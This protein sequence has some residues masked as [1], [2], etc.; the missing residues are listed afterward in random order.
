MPLKASAFLFNS[1]SFVTCPPPH[2]TQKMQAAKNPPSTPTATV[3]VI[4]ENLAVA[5]AYFPAAMAQPGWRSPLPAASVAPAS[6]KD[7][8]RAVTCHACGGTPA[9]TVRVMLPTLIVSV[10]LT[11]PTPETASSTP[12]P[13]LPSKSSFAVAAHSPM[14]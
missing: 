6:N 1:S 3:V 11:R 2:H 8:L 7:K 10:V 4:P 12:A 14:L 9:H 13:V 5:L